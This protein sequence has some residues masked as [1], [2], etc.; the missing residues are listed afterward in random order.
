MASEIG[1]PDW[2]RPSAV[3]ALTLESSSWARDGGLA[4]FL[5][6]SMKKSEVGEPDWGSSLASYWA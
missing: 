2:G 5:R 1:E 6:P 4:S 3:V